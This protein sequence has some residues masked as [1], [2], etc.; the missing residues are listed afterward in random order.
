MAPGLLPSLLRG[1]LVPIF[2]SSTP[3][4]I[5]CIS[6]L[7]RQMNRQNMAPKVFYNCFEDQ[8]PFVRNL[9]NFASSLKFKVQIREHEL[10]LSRKI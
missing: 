2:N 10:Y 4:E 9:P 8:E 1:L 7:G 3:F 6:N 5:V